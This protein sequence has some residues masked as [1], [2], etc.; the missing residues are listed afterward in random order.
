MPG[1]QNTMHI[2]FEPLVCTVV[3]NAVIGT[4]PALT[5]RSKN[6]KKFLKMSELMI[7]AN[8]LV[9]HIEENREN[10]RLLAAVFC[11]SLF[12]Y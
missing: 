9:L 4:I 11:L 6:G 5:F 1:L 3:L 2:I 12:V 10:W 7:S 8:E